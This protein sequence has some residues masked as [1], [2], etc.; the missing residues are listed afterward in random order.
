MNS[1][2]S[3]GLEKYLAQQYI[4]GAT[5]LMALL[6]VIIGS[7]EQYLGIQ[8]HMEID[9]VA[10]K[11]YYFLA[12]DI[13][14]VLSLD[15]EHRLQSGKDCLDEMYNRFRKTTENAN[16][17]TRKYEDPLFEN[18]TNSKDIGIEILPNVLQ[19]SE[20]LASDSGSD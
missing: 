4:S 3:V 17:L 2:A 8:A 5:C 9:L 1:V 12:T 19:S 7:I 18:P 15:R 13:F 16:V 10:S 6:V 11:D 14:K 20:E